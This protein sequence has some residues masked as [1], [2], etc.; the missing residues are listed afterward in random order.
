[1]HVPRRDIRGGYVINSNCTSNDP[2]AT[3]WAGSHKEKFWIVNDTLRFRGVGSWL[4]S[5]NSACAVEDMPDGFLN[6]RAGPGMRYA[7]KAKLIT[8]DEFT[9]VGDDG[10]EWVRVNV[11]RLHIAGWVHVDYV[12]RISCAERSQQ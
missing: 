9:V 11:G 10:E 3:W 2:N 5:S 1:M 12:K 8:G 6:L 4:D 7:V